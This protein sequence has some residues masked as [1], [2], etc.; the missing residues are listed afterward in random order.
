MK[1]TKEK[2]PVALIFSDAHLQKRTWQNRP[3]L[4]DS[5]YAL[6]QIVDYALAH[7][8][9]CVLGAGDLLDEKVNDSAPIL[10][11]REQLERLTSRGIHFLFVQGQHEL[12]DPPWMLLGGS[13]Y[14]VHLHG[15]SW[16]IGNWTVHGLDYQPADRIQEGLA[17]I[18]EDAD[19]LMC[20]QVFGDFMGEVALPQLDFADVPHVKQVWT[21]DFHQFVL[22][23]DKYRGKQGQKLTVLSCGATHQCPDISSPSE[24]YFAT[25]DVDGALTP[26]QLKTRKCDEWKVVNEDQ[27]QE[28]LKDIPAYLEGAA[29]YASDL[30][31]PP[32][33][34][35]P[36]WR[37]IYNSRIDRAEQRTR[38][39]VGDDAHLFFK[40]VPNITTTDVER[41]LRPTGKVLT[42]QS[43]LNEE[44]DPAQ[45]PDVY[46]LCQRLLQAG[47]TPNDLKQELVR[48]KQEI[49]Q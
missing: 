38:K 31:L 2:P 23:R 10:F 35:K 9:G 3:I 30:E 43:C 24:C 37:L 29:N 13:K 5:Y 32:Q 41:M 28:F 19:I 14:V 25:I 40:E 33:L 21:G 39:I 16:T 20:H 47:S 46:K 12:T 18:P 48:W 7:K 26:H 11:L 1:P 27:F 22:E 45:Q 15:Q 44:V 4:G 17:G 34:Q 42:L 49:L 6:E 8:I 36:L